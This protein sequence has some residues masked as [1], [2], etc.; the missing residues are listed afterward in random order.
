[1]TM[2]DKKTKW[3]EELED[4]GKRKDDPV[5]DG[6]VQ[7]GGYVEEAVTT[8]EK[9]VKDIREQTQKGLLERTKEIQDVRGEMA[10][11]FEVVGTKL[12]G[13]RKSQVIMGTAF[14]RDVTND[15]VA[16]IPTEKRHLIGLAERT[17]GSSDNPSGRTIKEQG[18]MA[19]PIFKAATALWFADSAK[20][21]LPQFN[22]GNSG[23]IDEIT[24]LEAAFSASYMDVTTKGVTDQSETLAG[25]LIPAPVENEVLRLINDNSIFR[26]LVRK[27]TMTSK[28]LAIPTKGNAITAYIGA[29]AATLTGSYD[30][31]AFSSVTLT[32]KRFHGAVTMSIELLEDSIVGLMP[33]ILTTLGE[34]IGTLE[35]QETVDGAGTNFTGLIAATGVNSVAT[36]TTNGEAI[37]YG[38]L[39]ATIFK[40]RQRASRV[41]ARWIMAPEQFG[42][43]A[44]M[45]DSNGQPIVQYGRVPNEIVPQILGFPVE[46]IS[47]ISITTTRG[48]TGGTSNVY[49]GP[50]TAIIFGDRTGMRWDVSDAPGWNK[51]Q[52]AARLVKRT[53]IVIGVPTAW[54]K[55]VGGTV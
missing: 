28:T 54:T 27:I 4:L 52:M 53:G 47:T 44:G 39:T 49:F 6:V 21:Q 8:M 3:L 18:R 12:D 35:D 22:R 17:M 48:S 10:A 36:T 29:E 2:S 15:L 26:P 25:S 45:V 9:N 16:A 13:I 24:K 41:N 5:L 37:V 33:Y 32:A 1:M 40:A 30:Q 55:L 51:Y 34:E 20:L 7:I 31:T 38:D 42:A 14:A 11:G 19:D 50:P 46:I 23:L 43:I